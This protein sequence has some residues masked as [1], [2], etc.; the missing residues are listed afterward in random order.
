ME[1]NVPFNIG[2]PPST[3]PG[4]WVHT[5]CATQ[6]MPVSAYAM[7]CVCV[8]NEQVS[9]KVG[10]VVRSFLSPVKFWVALTASSLSEILC[11]LIY[12]STQ[13]IRINFKTYISSTYTWV[14]MVPTNSLGFL[15][16]YLKG[17]SYALNRHGQKAKAEFNTYIFSSIGNRLC[18]F[19]TYLGEPERNGSSS[20]IFFKW[21]L[22]SWESS[23]NSSS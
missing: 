11:T 16:M 17:D 19:S 23:S 13:I 18:N 3:D 9:Q 2:F 7:V 6:K 20:F 4:C 1:W 12:K 21:I 14:Y 15:M 22:M 10:S 8:W 5:L